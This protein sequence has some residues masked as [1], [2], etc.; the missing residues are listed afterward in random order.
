MQNASYFSLT[1]EYAFILLPAFFSGINCYEMADAIYTVY[2]Q[3]PNYTLPPLFND[4]DEPSVYIQPQ[5]V[6]HRALSTTINNK[7]LVLLNFNPRTDGSQ[8]RSRL[9]K[10][11]CEPENKQNITYA[12]CFLKPGGVQINN[13]PNIYKRNRQYPFWLSPRGGGIDCHRTWEALYL[14]IIPIV[15]NN[16]LNVLY[17]NLPVLIINGHE[18]LN[19]KFLYAKL[20]EISTKKLSKEKVYQYEKLWNAYWRRLILDKS[21]YRGKKNV[22]VRENRCWRANRTVEWKRFIPFL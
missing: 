4:S 18:E 10:I 19:E 2:S 11:M 9:W 1:T 22:H 15:W 8:S 13:L 16:S 14:D 20:N 6:S 7:E 17:E 12:T 5:D 21:R 3:Q